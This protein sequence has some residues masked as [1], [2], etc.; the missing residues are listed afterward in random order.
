LKFLWKW[1]LGRW[2]F[3]FLRGMPF[4]NDH[5]TQL[6]E[7]CPQFVTDLADLIGAA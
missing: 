5:R 3:S 1:Q 2:R 4:P 6:G 7:R